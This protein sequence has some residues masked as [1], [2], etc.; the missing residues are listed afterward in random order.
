VTEPLEQRIRAAAASAATLQGLVREGLDE[1][2]PVAT[3][4][5]WAGITR[6]TVYNWARSTERTPPPAR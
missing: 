6:Q 4:A 5:R 2:V 3:L 1:G